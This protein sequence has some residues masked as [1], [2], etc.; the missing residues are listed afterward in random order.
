MVYPTDEE[1]FDARVS[2]EWIKE[3][4][5]NDVQAL[6]KR[7]QDF[8]GY[9]GRLHDEKGLVNP[10]G[11]ISPYPGVTA[12]DGWLLCD[13]QSYNRVHADY[14]DLFAVIGTQYGAITAFVFSVPDLRGTFLRGYSKIPTI[15]FVPADV[16]TGTEFINLTNHKFYRSGFPVRFTTD[17]TLPAPLVINTTY[18]IIYNGTDNVALATTRANA[19]ALT[20]I[21]LTSTGVGTSYTVPWLEEDKADRLKLAFGGN[22]GEDLGSFQPDSFQGHYHDDTFGGSSMLS[23][24]NTDKAEPG[25]GATAEMITLEVQGALSDGVHGTP[26]VGIESRPRNVNVNYIIKR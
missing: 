4:H 22:D 16:N 12:P 15:S 21:N 6:L 5:L 25:G 8:I 18:Y 26:R 9:G 17:D 10:A 19:I 14:A 11:I 3:G 24:R 23:A 13:G 2:P 1:T 20:S 7:I